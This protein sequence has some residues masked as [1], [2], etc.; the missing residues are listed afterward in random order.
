MSHLENPGHDSMRRLGSKLER[1][2]GVRSLSL[3]LGAIG[4][5]GNKVWGAFNTETYWR[6]L[7]VLWIRRCGDCS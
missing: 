5:R 2:S 4:Q 1:G 3:L 6:I 7:T